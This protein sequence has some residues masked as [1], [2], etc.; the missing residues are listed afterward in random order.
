MRR[1]WFAAGL[2]LATTSALSFADDRHPDRELRVYGAQL[3]PESVEVTVFEQHDKAV[4]IKGNITLNQKQW[5]AFS[6]ALAR[7]GFLVSHG[8]PKPIIFSP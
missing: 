7:A 2:A 3:S 5:E 1:L 6:K 4:D 8:E